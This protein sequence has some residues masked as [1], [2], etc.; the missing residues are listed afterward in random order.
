VVVVAASRDEEGLVAE[1]S[2]GVEAERVHI[3]LPRG[4]DVADRQVDVANLGAAE[5]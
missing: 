4:R 5:D 1:R 3:E 2:G